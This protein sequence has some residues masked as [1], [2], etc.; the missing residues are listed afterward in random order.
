LDKNNFTIIM[1]AVFLVNLAGCVS[2]DSR[3]HG[4]CRGLYPGV[5]EDIVIIKTGGACMDICFPTAERI[6]SIIDLPFSF[7]L[8]TICLPFDAFQK[9]EKKEEQLLKKYNDIETEPKNITSPAAQ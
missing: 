9:C 2:I 4:G 5:T 3:S 6:F 1:I 7:A 8:D